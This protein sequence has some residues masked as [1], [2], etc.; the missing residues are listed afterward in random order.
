MREAMVSLRSF[1]CPFVLMLIVLSVIS[2]TAASSPLQYRTFINGSALWI[3]EPAGITLYRNDTRSVRSVVLCDTVDNDTI[4]DITENSNILWVIAA[5]GIY[6]IDL[7][8]TTVEKLPGNKKGAVNSRIAVDDDYLWVGISDTLWRF[9]KLGREWFPYPVKSGSNSLCGMYSNGTNVYCVQSSSIKIFSTKDEKWRDFPYPK[10]IVISPVA[11]FFL[12]KN[13]LVLVE[14]ASIYRYIIDAQSWDVISAG[15][16]IVDMLSQDTVIF[17]QTAKEMFEYFTA[18]SV[19]RPL[20]IPG[21]SDSRCFAR[22]A[23]TLL[24]CATRKN[25]IK[26]DISA[27]ITDNIEAPQNI[28][29]F[30][31]LKTIMFKDTLIA[32][33]P[34]AIG[35]CDTKSPLWESIHLFAASKN[36]TAFVWNDNNGAKFNY[37][38]GCYS[39]LRGN[40]QQSLIIDSV[41]KAGIYYGLSVPLI[42]LTLHNQFLKGNYYDVYFDNSD[43]TQV[44][45]KGMFYRGATDE[46]MESARLGTNTI[47]IPQSNTIPQSQFEG[48]NIILQSKSS[49]STRDRRIV[50]AQAGGGLLT[51]QTIYEVLPYTESGYYALT[52]FKS[53]TQVKKIIV[54]GSC[55]IAIDGENIDSTD[56]SFGTDGSITFNRQDILDPSSIIKVSYQVRTIPDLLP[57]QHPRDVVEF[58]PEN[59]FGK[60]GYG[61]V[62]VSPTDWISPQVGFA[63]LVIDSVHRHEL[64][65]FSTPSEIRTNSTGLFLKFNPEITYDAE[66]RAKAAAL[67]LQSRFGEKLSLLFNGLLPDSRFVT[68]DN[69]DRGYGFIKH[70][71][72]FTIDYD[73]RKELP[74]SYYQ[75]DIISAHGIERYYALSAGSHFQGFPF[76]DV[77]LSRNVVITDINDTITVAHVVRDTVS[78][79]LVPGKIDTILRTTYSDSITYAFDR[80]KDKF[81][82]RLHETSSPIIES[83]LHINR[84][85]YDLS[86]TGF[87]SRKEGLGETGY[88][89]IFYGLG[90]IS[91][92]KRLTLTLRGTYMKNPIGSLYGSEYDPSFILQTI[93]A[94]PGFDISAHS[95]LTFKNIAGADSSFSL[96]QRFVSLTVKPGVW[97]SGMSWIQPIVGINQTIN[98]GFDEYS[99]GINELLLANDHIVSKVTTPNIGA[100]IFP[101]NDITFR[102]D[103]QFTTA[104]SI[105]T[106]YLFNDLKWWFGGKRFWQTRWE[107]NRDR[108]RFGNGRSRDYN[109]GF[110]KFIS[111]WTPWLQTTTGISSNITVTDSTNQT[112]IGPDIIVSFNTGKFLFVRSFLNSHTLNVSWVKN[113]GILQ[114]SPDISYALYLKLTILPNLS[115]MTNNTL[116]VTHGSPIKFNGR[117]TASAF[118]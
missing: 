32:L 44:P 17:Y 14:G 12:D 91:P 3:A 18:T 40:V 95:E 117:I 28:S 38:K 11:Q 9:D 75:N 63:H 84:L 59:N 61:S 86:Y 85:N 96:L 1:I 99:P 79:T 94:P 111:D 70:K 108:P 97:L 109:R 56:F 43:I 25:Y 67:S 78:D 68:T 93:D 36:S 76:L 29:N 81:R 5:S 83:F 100:N 22:S 31:V 103:N 37:A 92:I 46:R 55:K 73:I 20:D 54:P 105:T 98:C 16:P 27:K 69:L 118:F 88:G 90:T 48:G 57:G 8:T 53:D 6:Q 62:T 112:K 45:R 41:N 113:N 4:R 50:K 107:Y 66:T 106:Y 33:C 82:V 115:F 110:S 15:S 74:L 39:Q 7:T 2:A 13:A 89:S 101:T 49:L 71:T 47:T 65:N 34:D 51:T 102:N 10:D 64:V 52:S 23:D 24:Y 21:I 30:S 19:M 104:D 26:Y 77:S 42:S 116:T 35:V 60:L 80:N 114:S 58:V 72:D 87:T